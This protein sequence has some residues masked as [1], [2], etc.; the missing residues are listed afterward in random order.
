MFSACI[1]LTLNICIYYSEWKEVTSKMKAVLILL[2]IAATKAFTE[3]Y[4]L[5]NSCSCGSLFINCYLFQGIRPGTFRVADK[6]TI[7]SIS[8]VQS[9]VYFLEFVNDF[10]GLKRLMFV[11]SRVN[12]TGLEGVAV[13]FPNLYIEDSGFCPGT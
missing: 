2:C 7:Q 1:S 9:N 12:C 11:D 4:C 10:P 3:N 8:F 13:R 5:S 6:E